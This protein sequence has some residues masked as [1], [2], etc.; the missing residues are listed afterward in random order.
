MSCGI[1]TIVVMSDSSP[2]NRRARETEKLQG[3]CLPSLKDRLNES[4]TKL[5]RAPYLL[6]H[7]GQKIG[8]GPLLCALAAYFINLTDEEQYRMAEEGVR[9]Y[10]EMEVQAE[11]TPLVH[12][13][14]GTGPGVPAQPHPTRRRRSG[15]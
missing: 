3:R 14:A 11:A 10:E 7:A 8:H 4:K 13:Q 15:S 12:V 1:S 5:S 2:K 6:K 9:L